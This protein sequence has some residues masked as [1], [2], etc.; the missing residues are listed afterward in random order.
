MVHVYYANI[1]NFNDLLFKI[2]TD[3]EYPFSPPKVFISTGKYKE[4]TILELYR[5]TRLGQNELNELIPSMKCLCCFTI[6]CSEKWSPT[7]NILDVLKEI[8][9][10]L[11]LRDRIRTRVIARFFQRKERKLPADL[12][13]EIIQFI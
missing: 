11:N 8:E 2:R 10:F 4:T 7:N 5:T 6:L 1:S 3:G 12:W 9:F 13:N